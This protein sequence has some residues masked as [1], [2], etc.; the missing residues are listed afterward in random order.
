[1]SC[2]LYKILGV[3]KTAQ[4][5]EIKKA[6]QKLA[7]QFHPD[8]HTNSP[9]QTRAAAVENFKQITDAYE[10]LIDDRKSA[11]YDLRSASRKHYQNAGQSRQSYNHTKSPAGGG[12][13]ADSNYL[14]RRAAATLKKLREFFRV[15]VE[16]TW[17]TI[18]DVVKII[19][20]LDF[21][22]RVIIAIVKRL[23]L[24]QPTRTRCTPEPEK[25]R[26]TTAPPRPSRPIPVARAHAAQSPLSTTHVESRTTLHHP[27]ARL[28]D[29]THSALAADGI[30]RLSS[31]EKNRLSSSGQ[32]QL[33]PEQSR[34]LL[35]LRQRLQQAPP[36]SSSGQLPF[37]RL[38]SEDEKKKEPS[39]RKL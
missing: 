15:S 12:A 8:K 13:Q 38:Q 24:L 17:E 39:F 29:S 32:R 3:A 27:P 5:Q 22:L 11:A 28:H 25:P 10:T 34:P 16:S 30:M 37:S 7:F 35:L 18:F 31:L 26:T 21:I 4:K 33:A 9:P 20:V 2:R 23:L 14:K 19:I 36:L 1:M 6:Y